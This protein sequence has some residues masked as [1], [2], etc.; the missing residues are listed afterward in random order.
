MSDTNTL[1]SA[2]TYAQAAFEHAL[3]KK[4][5]ETWQENLKTLAEIVKDNSVQQVLHNP[6]YT[7][8]QRVEM[9]ETIMPE[10][11]QD[12]QNYI[13]LLTENNR[14]DLLPAIYLF[15]TEYVL[16]YEKIL[17]A[18]VYSV[19]KLDENF[20]Q[21]LAKA[22]S[23]KTQRDVKLRCHI[24]PDLIGGL[25]IRMGDRVIDYSIRNE[26]NRMRQQLLS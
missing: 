10:L 3:S 11:E 18:D 25:L 1:S 24:Q 6:K 20:Q 22:L 4:Q 23:K 15:F 16:D 14:L 5:L 12:M 8:E 13:K 9:L 2:R 17:H 19:I 26:L 7:N 21:R